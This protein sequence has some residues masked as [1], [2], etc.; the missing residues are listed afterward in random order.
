M[1]L[2]RF[3][4]IEN[5]KQ[6]FEAIKYVASEVSKLANEITNETY[7]ISYLTVFTHYPEE[8][9]KLTEMF[10][11]LGEVSDANNGLKVTLNEPVEEIKQLRIRKP[12]PYRM[13]VGCA[14]LSIGNYDAFKKKHLENSQNLRLM[15]RPEYEMIEFFHPDFDVLAYIMSKSI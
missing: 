2:Y 10:S 11:D 12:D 3:S 5:K 14:D 15:E 13:Q 6:L 1:K 4:P 9:Q 8:Y 7:P